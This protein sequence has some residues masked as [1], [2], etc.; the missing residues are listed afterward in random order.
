MRMHEFKSSIAST[1]TNQGFDVLKEDF[2][3]SVISAVLLGLVGAAYVARR[4]SQRK[5]LNAAWK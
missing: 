4:L 3:Y 2:D 5:A 1:I